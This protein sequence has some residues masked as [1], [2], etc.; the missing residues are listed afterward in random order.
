MAS[1][2]KAE[3]QR[4][5]RARHGARTGQPGRPATEPCGTVAAYRRH[6]KAGED[7]C[8]ACRD[9]WNAKQREMYQARKAKNNGT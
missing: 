4:E 9:A 2:S 5:W 8:A 6:R 7:P 3:Y 1:P